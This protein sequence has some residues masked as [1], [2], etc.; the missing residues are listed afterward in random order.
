MKVARARFYPTFIIS[1]A[2]G[3]EAFNPRYFLITPEALAGGIAG[4]LVAPLINKRAIQAEYMSANA[5]QLQAVYNYQ[6]VILNAFT[7]VINRVT[8]EQNYRKSIEIKKEQV[9]ALVASVDSATKLFRAARPEVD[10]MDVLFAQRDLLEARR[11]LI[12][13]KRQ[14]LSAVVN[15]YQALGGGLVLNPGAAG[16]PPQGAFTHTVRPGET[17]KTISQLYYTSD[18]YYKA[19]WAANKGAVP[20]PDILNVGENIVIPPVAQLDPALYEQQLPAAS[21]NTPA[22]PDQSN[23]PQ[24]PPPDAPGPFR[25]EEPA[26]N[27]PAPLDPLDV[28]QAE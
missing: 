8:M 27:P 14:Q 2:V 6:R 10:Y 3:Y 13:T 11:V 26:S 16:N 19:L 25:P 21:P 22:S 15:A 7:E 23:P 4:N 24:P 20:T 5:T 18:R 9:R 17:F 12:E 28:P 1:G